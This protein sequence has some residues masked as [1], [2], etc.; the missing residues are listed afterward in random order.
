MGD[1]VGRCNCAV[2]GRPANFDNSRAKAYCVCSRCGLGLFRYFLSRLS[3]L[4]SIS[5]P[6][7][8]GPKYIEILLK[9]CFK[10]PLTPKQPTN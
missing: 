2:V 4:S 3:F 9:Y 8:D 1:R 5:L 10:R 6:L 7:G